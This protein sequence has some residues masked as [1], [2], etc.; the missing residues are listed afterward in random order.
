MSDLAENIEQ[1]I[2]TEPQ[3]S[4]L[5]DLIKERDGV[6]PEILTAEEVQ[7]AKEKNKEVKAAKEEKQVKEKPS[8]DGDTEKQKKPLEPKKAENENKAPEKKESLDEDDL[9]DIEVEKLKKA[10]NDSQKWGHSNNKRLKSTLKMISSLKE[11]G[12]LTDD[13]FSKLND[14]LHSDSVEEEPITEVSNNPLINLSQ[15]ANKR[16][17]DLQELYGHDPL[18]NKKVGAFDSYVRD[19]SDQEID[20]ILEELEDLKGSPLKLAKKMFDMGE[21][22]YNNIYSGLEKSG[23]LRAFIDEKNSEIAKMKKKIDKLETKLLQSNDYDD[24]PT[25]KID[26]LSE[27]V[28]DDVTT[29]KPN[30]VLGQTMAERDRKRR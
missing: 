3:I 27:V 16:I 7:E 29:Y 11:E 20:E 5:D 28:T 12:S 30:D 24:K 17:G 22:F 2:D 25:L 9:H 21:T 14:L 26:E 19:A 15:I 4:T 13:E 8:E 1:V 23:G 10:L 18:F 6:K